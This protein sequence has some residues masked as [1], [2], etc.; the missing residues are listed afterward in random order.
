MGGPAIDPS[1][2][3]PLLL[4]GVG[5]TTFFVTVLFLRV[6]AEILAAKIRAIR[7]TQVRGQGVG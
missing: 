2:L 1:M 3:A 4:M 7:L 6:R 5:F